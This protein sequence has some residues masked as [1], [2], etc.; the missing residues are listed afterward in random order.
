MSITRQQLMRARKLIEKKRYTQAR[1]V[2]LITEHPIADKWLYKVDAILQKQKPR[3]SN[4]VWLYV[5]MLLFI[6]SV[7]CYALIIAPYLA[8]SQQV[9]N[10]VCANTG[11]C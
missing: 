10:D 6:S 4:H 3:K 1:K 11:A 2:L 8:Q 9:I 7:L 5:A